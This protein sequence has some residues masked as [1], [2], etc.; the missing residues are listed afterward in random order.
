MAENA[1]VVRVARAVAR[2]FAQPLSGALSYSELLLL[3]RAQ[4]S[5]DAR[6]QVEGLREGVLHLNQLLQTLRTTV[7]HAPSA[8]PTRHVADDVE[9]SVTEPRPRPRV[10]APLR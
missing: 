1:A 2:E 3:E 10:G 9:R 7:D 4:L 5:A 6:Y 8:D